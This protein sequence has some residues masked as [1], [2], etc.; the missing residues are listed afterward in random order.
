MYDLHKKNLLN[1]CQLHIILIIPALSLEIDFKYILINR[2][3]ES[4]KGKKKFIL[5]KLFI[6][7]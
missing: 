6:I 5:K 7:K 4:S 1:K 2:S 3:T